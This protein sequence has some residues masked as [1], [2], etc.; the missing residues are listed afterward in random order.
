MLIS[1]IRNRSPQSTVVDRSN[2]GGHAEG[3]RQVIVD[4]LVEGP[5]E[6]DRDVTGSGQGPRV[7]LPGILGE[8]ELGSAS[9]SLMVWFT[10]GTL[11]MEEWAADGML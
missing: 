2:H 1:S 4:G 9:W 3:E 11:C 5:G 6:E 10:G 8:L 7:V